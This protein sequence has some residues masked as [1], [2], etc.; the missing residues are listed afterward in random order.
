MLVAAADAGMRNRGSRTIVSW[1]VATPAEAQ[2]AEIESDYAP[3]IV[4]VAVLEAPGKLASQTP[5][6]GE[7][8]SAGTV[9]GNF[10]K[11]DD[12]ILMCQHV[13]SCVRGGCGAGVFHGEEATAAG[14]HSNRL[15]PPRGLWLAYPLRCRGY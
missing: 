15:H 5:R 10:S 7:S 9:P 11:P 14:A 3:E 4:E 12:Y 13:Y 1:R 8:A 2:V 6:T